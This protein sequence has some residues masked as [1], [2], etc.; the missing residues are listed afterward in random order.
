MKIQTERDEGVL[1]K[2]L[3]IKGKLFTFNMA[4]FAGSALNFRGSRVNF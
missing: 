4:N 3:M 2:I 1:M